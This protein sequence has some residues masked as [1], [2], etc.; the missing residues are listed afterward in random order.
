MID[1]VEHITQLLAP[2]GV[3]VGFQTLPQSAEKPTQYITFLEI[4]EDPAFEAGD[5]ELVT[6]RLVQVNI[7]SKVNYHHLAMSV[8]S[9]MEGAGFQRT[10][11]YD[12]PYTDGDS[13]Y[14]KVMRFVYEDEY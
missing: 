13:H 11:V 12:V 8:R 5:G 10:F 6:G 2:T 7:W 3:P 9:A 4:V 14:N 1:I